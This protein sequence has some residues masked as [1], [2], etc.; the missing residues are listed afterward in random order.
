MGER[1]GTVASIPGNEGRITQAWANVRGGMRMFAVYF[2][3]S[4]GWTPWKR[5]RVT[6]HPWLVSC[7]ANMS[8]VE[9]EGTRGEW[10]EKVYDNVIAC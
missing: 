4:E 1:E 9:F 8:P 6:I 3:H 7:D 2:W 5:A 10:I